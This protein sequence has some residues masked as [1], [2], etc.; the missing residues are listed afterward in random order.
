MLEQ[1]KEI[2]AI[3]TLIDITQTSNVRGS[4]KTRNQQ[5]NFETLLQTVNI[6]TQTWALGTP[7]REKWS[8]FQKAFKGPGTSFGTKHEF[9]QEII[10]DL[11]V[12]TWRFGVEHSEV[13]GKHGDLLVNQLHNIPVITGLD[14]NC[15][16]DVSAFDTQSTENRNV[17]II[18]E[19][20]L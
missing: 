2:W 11:N 3:K 9:S 7:K 18:C 8:Q 14:E 16:L 1:Y 10:V 20:L 17:L 15:Y 19:T 4:G 13:F 12:W 5:R 6:L